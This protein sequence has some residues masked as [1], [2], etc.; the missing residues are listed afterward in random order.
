MSALRIFSLACLHVITASL[1]VAQEMPRKDSDGNP[2]PPG[3]IARIGSPRFRVPGPVM[4]ARFVD[5]GSKLLVRVK[6]SNDSIRGET[7]SFRLIDTYRALELASMPM[8][9]MT[10]LGHYGSSDRDVQGGI[11]FPNWCIS[12][13]GTLVANTE[14]WPFAELQIRELL[15]GKLLFDIQ[16]ENHGFRFVQF[17]PDGKKVAVVGVVAENKREK[18]QS[19]VF[20]RMYDL[21][22]RKEVR[23]FRPP[24]GVT[25]SF[26]A[27]WFTFSPDGLMLAATGYEEGK[28]GIVRI[29]DVAGKHSSWQ[30]EGQTEK[31][32]QPRAIA[33]SP[34]GK[35][36][37]AV[38][39]GKIRLWD[40]VTGKRLKDVAK[41]TGDCT[42]I[43]FSPDGKCLFA[44]FKNAREQSGMW[45]LATGKEI[46][47]PVAGEVS[48]VFS[49]SGATLV[50][51]EAGKDYA[52]VCAAATGQVQ[53][54]IAI[55]IPSPTVF[56]QISPVA[57]NFYR[58]KQGMGW[59]F[60]LSPDS[61][62]LVACGQA[63]QI[64]RF[65]TATG[66]EIAAPGLKA[67][68]APLLAFS[69]DGKKLFAAGN[70][71]AF[72][73]Q[74][75]GNGTSI[76]MRIDHSAD[77]K[78]SPK[79][80]LEPNALAYSSDGKHAAVGWDN[81]T[82]DLWESAT[83]NRLWQ[84]HDH[85]LPISSLAFAPDERTLVSAGTYDGRVIWRDTATGKIQ[86]ALIRD[87]DKKLFQR[88]HF[89][90]GPV[91][92]TALFSHLKSF[93]EIE[94]SSGGLRRQLSFSEDVL[95]T[96]PDGKYFLVANWGCYRLIDSVSGEEI[97]SFGHVDGDEKAIYNPHGLAQ[98]S[99]DGRFLVGAAG[100]EIV[101]VWDTATGTLLA[102]LPAH[103]G[104]VL[105]VAIAP[106]A[107]T[108]A[109]SAGN[110]A[111]F[112]WNMPPGPAKAS[113]KGKIQPLPTT[114]MGMD[115]Q[116]KDG[117]TLPDGARARLGPRRFQYGTFV[118][119]LRYSQDGNSILALA[120]GS[121]IL[122][123]ANTGKIENE[124][125]PPANFRG[126]F[127]S[128]PLPPHTYWTVS[129]DGKYLASTRFG[130]S[131][132][133]IATGKTIYKTNDPKKRGLYLYFTP[134]SKRVLDTAELTLIDFT[135]GTE[136]K[137][138]E[139]DD[140]TW[141][142]DIR[143]WRDV[144]F[145][146][147]SDYILGNNSS[148]IVDVVSLKA[149]GKKVNL[150]RKFSFCNLASFAPDSKRVA[151]LA[152]AEGQVKPRLVV[153]DLASGNV[154]HDFGEQVEKTERLFFS[155]DGKQL[156]T[157]STK[158]EKDERY[159]PG[160]PA[161]T[162]QRWDSVSGKKLPAI[163]LANKGLAAYTPDG[164]ALVIAGDGQLRLLDAVSSKEIRR[165]PVN[166]SVLTETLDWGEW[167]LDG[168]FAFSRDGKRFAIAV[169][170]TLRQFELATGKEIGPTPN[171][172][173]LFGLSVSKDGAWV[174]AL[175][176]DQVQ[177]WNTKD[178][179]VAFQVTP[180][181]GADNKDV[182]LT[183]TALS[184]DGR[185]LAAA[186]S[187]GVV[188]LFDVPSG[189]PVKHLRFHDTP[190]T[191]LVFLADKH[192]LLSCDVNGNLAHWNMDSGL[193]QKKQAP[194]AE[195]KKSTW[196]L[197][198]RS[199][200]TLIYIDTEKRVQRGNLS[201]FLAP[202]G[203]LVLP[204]EK[205]V[206]VLGG[207]SLKYQ[208][209]ASPKRD[210]NKPLVSQD[211]RLLVY[212]E[213]WRQTNLR[214]DAVLV[215]LVDLATGNEVRTLANFPGIADICLSPDGNLFAAWGTE[216]LRIWDTA[217]GT[218]LVSFHGHRGEVTSLS[219]SPD[220]GTLVSAGHDGSMVVWDIATLLAKPVVKDLTGGE[221]EVLW[222]Q[223]AASDA[224]VAGEA[225]HK[226]N[227]HPK[228][229]VTLLASQLKPPQAPANEAIA[230]FIAEL[231]SENSK[232][233]EKAFQELTKMGEF[234]EPALRVGL[235]VT[236]SLEHRLRV[237][238]LLDR[239]K[240]P[241]TDGG[242]LRALRSVEVLESAGTAEAIEVLRQLASGAENALVTRYAKGA[243][244]RKF[245][246]I[247]E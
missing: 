176:L 187:D 243:L 65:D 118:H 206:K 44:N 6:E 198:D 108:F 85:E 69:P 46:P 133:E 186:G 235:A 43:D 219:F 134:D 8:D 107:K 130:M 221:L 25:E 109:T 152:Q 123:N 160:R 196:R 202:N 144:Q 73:H 188:V 148:W 106:A 230:K 177:L 101:R 18:T 1:V 197:L 170:Y 72:L 167:R 150:A 155:P 77:P 79:K 94:L 24:L 50:L 120:G 137:L 48:Y 146:S 86:R 89:W 114:K 173:A 161:S 138:F 136:R 224:K 122:W 81:G 113:E 127:H 30:L 165:F 217:T 87:D 218:P 55:K 33:F 83:G 195:E 205:T 228:Q 4:G 181:R 36:L 169:G 247:L 97:R 112:L 98:F 163:V 164:K 88:G 214:E 67:D 168:P 225:M 71:F 231:D 215:H 92:K 84:S 51:A 135:T 211:G 21:Q 209:V 52:F 63:G 41:L 15:T 117:D 204:E 190:V 57:T 9:L 68:P 203:N 32:D 171:F 245:G 100:K 162:I 37:A 182:A 74:L 220:G 216:G 96:T 45:E 121:L 102:T 142:K 13:D 126:G 207:T 158:L 201:P 95:T 229:A 104:G 124:L 105:G 34:D 29:W 90:I 149:G 145:S 143:F 240:E 129:D 47:L 64:R 38:H 17:S 194:P 42:M 27:H 125:D 208:T 199:A 139:P 147:N 76:S 5:G 60:A 11:Y 115:R 31:R 132:E 174:A 35:T 210:D 151:I 246:R 140:E 116:D 159:D 172:Q 153:F 40:A 242:K 70:S 233:R 91:G 193:L 128:G 103:D 238:A 244:A 61:K 62:M 141:A 179:A 54:K 78:V 28:A 212:T 75:D 175:T 111:I 10:I 234:A 154:V 14:H 183:C 53:Q 166:A 237:V 222:K 232:V 59:P 80:T 226:L 22:T 3:A 119:G 93:Q 239:L 192:I 82:I 236:P 56:N 200:A 184:A 110:G 99:R 26:Q 156:A 185:R 213:R 49:A 189:K 223:L 7:G 39:D 241:I 20:I 178:N 16:E 2:L 191:G 131:V 180:W 66:K 157:L 12:P 19:P 58:A 227:G 23:T